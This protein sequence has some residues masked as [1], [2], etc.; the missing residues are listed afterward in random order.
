M[1]GYSFIAN[2]FGTRTLL[3]V[4]GMMYCNSVPSVRLVIPPYMSI[5]PSEPFSRHVHPHRQDPETPQ[6]LHSKRRGTNNARP[7]G[8]CNFFVFPTIDV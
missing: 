6:A 7:P 4:E 8:T 1:S 2:L 5:P 3:C